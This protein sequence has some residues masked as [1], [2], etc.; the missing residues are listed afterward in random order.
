MSP[1]EKPYSERLHEK[2]EE[3]V[4]EVD[5]NAIGARRSGA[6]QITPI[7]AIE[8]VGRLLDEIAR[9]AEMHRETAG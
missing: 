8:A 4:R 7:M 5:L 9:D 6:V 1:T 3:V 2:L